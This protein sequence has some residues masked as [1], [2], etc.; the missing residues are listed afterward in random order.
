MSLFHHPKPSESSQVSAISYRLR[1]LLYYQVK[2]QIY[3]VHIASLHLINL[4]WKSAVQSCKD[5][6]LSASA[7]RSTIY[8]GFETPWTTGP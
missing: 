4:M 8:Q 6:V 7:T 5:K 3:I 2:S 1:R